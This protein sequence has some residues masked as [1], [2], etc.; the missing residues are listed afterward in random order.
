MNFKKRLKQFPLKNNRG[1]G[2]IE[3]LVLVGLICVAAIGAVKVVGLNI[4][5][6]YERINR[7]MGAQTQ[8]DLTIR[9]ARDVGTQ[10]DLSDFFEN[11]RDNQ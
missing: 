5:T 4:H 8:G 6:Q 1:Q 11:A 10:R 3:Y 9:N 7:A 2:L